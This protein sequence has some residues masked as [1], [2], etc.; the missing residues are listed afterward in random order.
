GLSCSDRWWPACRSPPGYLAPTGGGPPAGHHRAILLRPVVARLRVSTGLSCSDRPW[1]ACG[2]VP[3][4]LAPT[5]RG[6]PAGQYRA[7]LLRPVVA[8][9]RV[10][11]GLSHGRITPA[12]RIRT[13]DPLGR[14]GRLARTVRAATAPGRRAAAAGVS[15]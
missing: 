10:S 5:G 14:C 13:V 2:S 7:I 11:T 8:R 4:Y 15:R 12:G 9:L 1:P 3:G 6:P